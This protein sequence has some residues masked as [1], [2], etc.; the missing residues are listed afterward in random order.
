MFGSFTYDEVEVIKEWI[1]SLSD[2]PCVVGNFYWTF[3][4][5]DASS[6]AALL[7]DQDIRCSYP[8]FSADYG[9]TFSHIPLDSISMLASGCLA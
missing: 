7:K 3:T 5:R 4:E 1:V 9:R 2:D 6:S 8:V